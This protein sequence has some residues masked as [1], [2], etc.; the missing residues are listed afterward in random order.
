MGELMQLPGSIPE[1]FSSSGG[2]GNMEA[3]VE[4]LEKDVSKIKVDLAIVKTK[5]EDHFPNFA[6]KSDIADVRTEIANTKSSIIQWMVGTMLASAG[7]AATIAFGLAK[8]LK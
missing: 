7:L 4:Q 6:T 1:R 8:I 2:G 3:R 5:I